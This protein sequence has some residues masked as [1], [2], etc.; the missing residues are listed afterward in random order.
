MNTD[1]AN[2]TALLK[3]TLNVGFIEAHYYSATVGFSVTTE[4]EI[5][6]LKIAY[7]Y[8][9]KQ[10]VHVEPTRNGN[11]LVSIPGFKAEAA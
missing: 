8:Q 3:Q 10:G 6:A 2:L 9:G 5:D 7:A 11:W 1:N 4:S